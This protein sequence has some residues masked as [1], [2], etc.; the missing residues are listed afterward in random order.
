MQNERNESA[1]VCGNRTVNLHV[2]LLRTRPRSLHQKHRHH[3]L[4]I[5][6]PD[7]LQDMRRSKIPSHDHV[8]T[9]W[10]TLF[11]CIFIFLFLR[12]ILKIT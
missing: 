10:K 12:L 4:D 9:T 7:I 11:L 2:L 5:N 8:S 3:M 1:S 6:F